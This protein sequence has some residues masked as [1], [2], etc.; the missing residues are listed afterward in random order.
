MGSLNYR[1]QVAPYDETLNAK[2]VSEIQRWS[3]RVA[4][5]LAAHADL[6]RD[7]FSF[8]AG[9]KYRE[10]LLPFLKNTDVPMEGLPIGKQLQFLKRATH[11]Q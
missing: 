1:K 3:A 7:R 4:E 9:R 5:Q 2:G 11:G 10:H 6:D 8:L